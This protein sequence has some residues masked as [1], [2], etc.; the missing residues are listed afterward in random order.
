MKEY[1]RFLAII[2]AISDEGDMGLSLV[3]C[4][5]LAEVMAAEAE[6]ITA[7]AFHTL[8]EKLTDTIQEFST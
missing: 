3:E 6:E 2:R 8:A 7:L 4:E 1:K 5:T